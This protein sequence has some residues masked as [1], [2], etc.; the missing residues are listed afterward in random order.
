MVGRPASKIDPLCI[1]HPG[2]DPFDGWSR[3]KKNNF[4]ISSSPKTG[5]IRPLSF[6]KNFCIKRP[7]IQSKKLYFCYLSWLSVNWRRYTAQNLETPSEMHK[8]A[9][10]EGLIS[11]DGSFRRERERKVLHPP[12]H[13]T[14]CPI[15][16]EPSVRGESTWTEEG[17][18]DGRE[19]DS[20]ETPS[21]PPLPYMVQYMMGNF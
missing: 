15:S 12:T 10:P 4:S 11:S 3:I 1:Q 14:S 20:K 8:A 13:H 16:R 6:P 9:P 21:L 19:L 2:P 17:G 7:F 5:Y 18:G